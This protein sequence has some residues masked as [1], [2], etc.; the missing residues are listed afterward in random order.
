[1]VVMRRMLLAARHLPY[2]GRQAFQ[3]VNQAEKRA[4]IRYQHLKHFG[5]LSHLHD[6][7]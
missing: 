3:S 1:M 6:H 5:D 4:V 2:P 7:L